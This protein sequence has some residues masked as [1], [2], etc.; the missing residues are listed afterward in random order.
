VKILGKLKFDEQ[1]LIPAIIQDAEGGQVLMMA[2]MNKDSLE[3]TLKTG[4]THFFSRSHRRIWKKGE[5]SGHVQRVKEILYDCD[6]DTILIKVEQE[7]AACHTGHRSC[8]FRRYDRC[9]QAVEEVEPAV[10]DPHE[11][12]KK[13]G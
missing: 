5:E 4:F 10:F 2:Y 13:E 3:Q 9:A 6:Q 1:G 11:V 8:F 12:Y 7:V